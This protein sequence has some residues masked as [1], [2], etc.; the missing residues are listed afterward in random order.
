M[1][2]RARAPRSI[3]EEMAFT[4]EELVARKRF[5]AFGDEDVTRLRG[6]NE[7]AIRHADDVIEGLYKHFLSHP[8]SAAYFRDP[9]VLARVK[10]KQRDYFLRLT[11]GEYDLEYVS[12]RLNIGAVHERID[13]PM[14]LYL[15]AYGYYLATVVEHLREE[16][17]DDPERVRQT[18]ISLI[19]LVF[20]DVG[21][22][23]D[24]YIQ[25]RE[26][27]IKLQQQA[28]L[29]LST[30]VLQIRDRLLLLPIVG[31]IDTDRARQ[32]TEQLLNSIRS[33]RAKVVVVDIT[34]VPTVDSRVANHLVQTVE[35]ARLMGAS[36]VVSGLSPAIAQT[37]VTLGVDLSK[38]NTVGDLQGG[39]EVAERMLGYR[40][41]R[42]ETTTG[43][44]R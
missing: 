26:R 25:R 2:D 29:E 31:A 42:E 12:D 32:L 19:R 35:A 33:S 6:I 18:M 5:L 39:I 27:T 7:L 11:A 43:G 28:I 8:E 9:A 15:G 21:L 17:P 38:I 23:I 30:P 37:L 41:V 16:F 20:L 40:T 36:C 10:Q 44:R 4:A 3:L 1:S 22:A 34:G 24:T 13:L 14:G